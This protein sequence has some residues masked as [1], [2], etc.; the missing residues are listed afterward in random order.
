MKDGKPGRISECPVGMI[1]RESPHVFDAIGAYGSGENVS[2]DVLRKPRWLQDAFRV[3]GSERARLFEMEQQDRK[4]Q[5]D[6]KIGA[7]MRSRHG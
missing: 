5:H 6:A 1:L 7:R 3:I 2:P 4:A